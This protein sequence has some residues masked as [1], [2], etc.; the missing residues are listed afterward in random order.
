MKCRMISTIA[1]LIGV[2]GVWYLIA[3]SS[4]QTYRREKEIRENAYKEGTE[5]G[6]WSV[7][8]DIETHTRWCDGE[9]FEYIVPDHFNDDQLKRYTFFAKRIDK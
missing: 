4:D 9:K 5:Y 3:K 7:L 1:G 2:F 6:K 8:Y